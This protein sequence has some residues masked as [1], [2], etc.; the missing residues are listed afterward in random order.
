MRRGTSLAVILAVAFGLRTHDLG[1]LSFWYDE[2]VTVRLART[3]SPSALVDLLNQI[4]ATRAPL[5][6]LMLQVWTRAFGPSETAARG[7]SVVF[8]LLTVLWVERLARRGFDDSSTGLW[9]AWLAAISPILIVYAREAR[10][11]AWLTLATCL[12]WDAILS[13]RLRSTLA[14]QAA[15]VVSLAILVY[16]HPL[17]IVMVAALGLTSLLGRS[18]LSLSLGRWVALHLM[19]GALVSPW[20]GH[21]FDHAPEMLI[22][23][24]SL[25]FLLG[26]PIGFLGGNFLTL[27]GFAV[28]IAWGATRLDGRRL[29]ID[30]PEITLGLLIWLTL[31]P[32]AL[33]AYSWFSH[34]IFGPPRYTLFVAPAYLILVGRGLARLPRWGGI[35]VGTGVSLLAISL[36][37]GQ[38]YAPDLKAD[39]RAMAARLDA[40]DPEAVE[41]IVVLTNATERN[42]EVETARYYIRQPERVVGWPTRDSTLTAR[43]TSGERIWV[44]VGVRQGRAVVELPSDLPVRRDALT[45]ETPGLRL[46]ELTPG[47]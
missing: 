36:L 43:L 3:A 33:F 10:M 2:V 46:I 5:H 41:P 40:L 29:R 35:A 9:A 22:G 27:V 26:M 47:P 14:R 15:Y 38:V 31:P 42:V 12:A 7:L 34:P 11:Y 21:Y 16:S 28:L 17:G 8:G 39:W 20:V 13:L 44:G 37:P 30:R 19:A 1:R 6:P 23:R 18:A 45:L 4:D 24:L 25:K 32:I